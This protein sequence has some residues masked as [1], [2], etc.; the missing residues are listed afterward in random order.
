MREIFLIDNLSSN[1]Q[2]SSYEDLAID[3]AQLVNENM[4][5]S[6]NQVYD[7][8]SLA[9]LGSNKTVE[10]YQTL[11]SKSYVI[12]VYERQVLLACG[13]L[14]I[15]DGRYFSKSLH[16]H[17]DYRGH[18]LAKF[19]C[20]ERERFLINLGERTIFIE[21]LKFPNTISFHQRRGFLPEVPYRELKH[22]ILMKKEL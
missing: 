5:Y 15:Q 13:F 6:N 3:I 2:N 1:H 9:K 20:D 10:A 14:T 17:P 21:S 19:I 8:V 12:A 22:T 16:V 7:E 18:G 11:I 4:A